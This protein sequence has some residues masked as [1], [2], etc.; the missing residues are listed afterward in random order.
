MTRTSTIRVGRNV[1]RGIGGVAVA[2]AL[3]VPFHSFEEILLFYVSVAL[4]AICLGGAYLLD[5][6]Q[7]IP[8]PPRN[9]KNDPSRPLG[10]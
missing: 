1:L 8:K 7:Q 2:V 6:E 4:A 3:F 9:S 5:M 10:L